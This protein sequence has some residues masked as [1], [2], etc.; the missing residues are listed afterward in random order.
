[1]CGDFILCR[2]V[3]GQVDHPGLPSNMVRHSMPGSAMDESKQQ[4]QHQ[5]HE[6]IRNGNRERV[7][8]RSIDFL[9]NGPQSWEDGLAREDE[10]DLMREFSGYLKLV[11]ETDQMPETPPRIANH[12]SRIN[13]EV[14]RNLVNPLFNTQ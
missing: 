14:L 2:T 6:G 1:M 10:E 5:L 8:G 7:D 11:E 13:H 4:L 12:P 9:D 3:I